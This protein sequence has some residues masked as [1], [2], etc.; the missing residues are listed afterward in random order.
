MEPFRFLRR[1]QDSFYCMWFSTC[2]ELQVTSV[3]D[4]A[5]CHY[6]IDDGV[7]KVSNEEEIKLEYKKVCACNI[8]YFCETYKISYYVQNVFFLHWRSCSQISAFGS[9]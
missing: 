6:N 5:R 4:T 8:F 7:S 1:S 2:H 3:C 9:V